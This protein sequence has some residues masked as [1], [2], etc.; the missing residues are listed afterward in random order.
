[1]S[2]Y[3]VLQFGNKPADSELQAVIKQEQNA[4]DST[5][6]LEKLNPQERKIVTDFVGQINLN[7]SDAVMT[8]GASAQNKV[9]EMSDNMLQNTKTKNLG[10]VGKDLTNLVVSIKSVS[11]SESNGGFL[12]IFGKAKNEV[13][14]MSASYAKVETNV[15][16]IVSVLEGHKRQL[17]KDVAMMDVMYEGNLQYFKEITLYIIAGQEKLKQFNEIDIAE[18]DRIAKQTGDEMEAQKL[19]DMRNIANRFEKKLHDLKLTRNIS[20]QLAPQIRLIQ[21]NDTALAEKIQSSIVNAIPLWKNQMVISLGLANSKAALEAQTKVTDMTNELL[22]KNSELLK[23]GSIDI[24]KESERGIVSVE[25]IRKTN[26]NLIATINEVL[27]IQKKGSE[28]RSA[29]ELELVKIEH[30]LKTALIAAST[31]K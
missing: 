28:E 27:E 23:Q 13:S 5:L 15:D 17:Y 21:N 2:D 20:L 3:P 9:A 29:A 7:D 31:R 22:M 25:T 4:P 10:E 19:S 8:F 11:S 1:M 16:R 24:A 30:E 12:G 6:T 26:E 18:Q 14:R